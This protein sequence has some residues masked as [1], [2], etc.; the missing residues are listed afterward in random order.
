VFQTGRPIGTGPV[1]PVAHRWYVTSTAAS[2]GPYRLC[3]GTK[4]PRTRPNARTV[5]RGRASPLQKTCRSPVQA[6]AAG[7]ARN[8]WSIDGTKWQTVTACSRMVRA[9]YAGSLWPPG[10]ATTS[11]APSRS[12]Q[13]NSHTDTSNPDGVFC[14]TR[15]PGESGYSCCIQRSR[16]SIAACDTTTPL[17]RPVEPEV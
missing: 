10:S 3:S 5:S 6:D 15:S 16:L 9:R 7:S 14:S 2:V 13:K 12:A 8:T 17:G 1:P 4:S 11:V